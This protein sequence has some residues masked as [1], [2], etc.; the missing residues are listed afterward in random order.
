MDTVSEVVKQTAKG[1]KFELLWGDFLDE[2]YRSGKE[3]KMDMVKDEP[4]HFDNIQAETYA[5]I[6]G[7][8]EKLC[9]DAE[10]E[11]PAWVFKDK[12]F[13]REPYFALNA[14]GM[15]RVV[16]LVESPNEFVVRNVFVSE[17]CLTR[18]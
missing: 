16:L 17:N 9:N 15:L 6:A 12:Y 2:F 1:Q 8:V 13:L 11:P 7:A 4:E 18:A 14:K 10:L 5:F 3:K